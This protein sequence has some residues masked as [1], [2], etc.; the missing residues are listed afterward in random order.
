[1]MHCPKIHEAM[2]W[3]LMY[4]DRITPDGGKLV[5]PLMGGPCC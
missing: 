4:I 2:E 5:V 1:M 3:Y